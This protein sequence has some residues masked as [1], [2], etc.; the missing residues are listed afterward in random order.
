MQAGTS[1]MAELV[2][3]ATLAR[4]KT[5]S[6]ARTVYGALGEH[7]D[8][9]EFR[10]YSETAAFL[11]YVDL[12]GDADHPETFH[13]ADRHKELLRRT[14]HHLRR[15]LR[16]TDK[17]D[18]EERNR[19]RHRPER[20]SVDEFCW[21]AWRQ[22]VYLTIPKSGDR[23][24]DTAV[25]HQVGLS[26]TTEQERLIRS[27]MLQELGV[28]LADVLSNED[29]ELLR[30]HYFEGKSQRELAALIAKHRSER[31][32]LAAENVINKRMSRARQRARERLANHWR[33]LLEEE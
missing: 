31:A 13:W 9:D 8:R 25:S 18:Y 26:D 4:R 12:G 17:N 5:A 14:Q 3:V 22:A 16:A 1:L 6:I 20:A 23:D 10:Q 33:K 7:V 29:L 32:I 2:D 27:T 15:L 28:A 11:A 21:D 30:Q 19:A 24:P